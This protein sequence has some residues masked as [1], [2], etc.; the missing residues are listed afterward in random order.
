MRTKNMYYTEGANTYNCTKDVSISV[1]EII[2]AENLYCSRSWDKEYATRYVLDLKTAIVEA[3]Y[4]KHYRGQRF[5]KSVLELPISYGCIIGCRHCASSQ[6]HHKR[7]LC[8]EELLSIFQFVASKHIPK[9]NY[10][11]RVSFAGIGE[12]AL[13]PHLIEHALPRMLS[14]YPNC[15]FTLTT[16]G[17]DPEYLPFT[18]MLAKRFPIQYLQ[19]SYL[20][21]D[22][23]LISKIIPTA[24]IFQ[25]NYNRLFNNIIHATSLPI[26][27]N[28]VV[29][30]DF[31][32][33]TATALRLAEHISSI[34]DRV[35]VRVSCMNETEPSRTYGLQPPS[36]ETLKSIYKIFT[37]KGITTYVFAAHHDDKLN[38]GQLAGKYQ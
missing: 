4:F 26:R 31:N 23:S 22:I 17:C 18:E 20:Q 33:D 34:K 25:F 6:L 7:F 13:V 15:Y 14:L 21:D 24:S 29:I 28:Y 12:G 16:S 38:C 36:M 8:L 11:F 19:I 37:N 35:I 2:T 3:S 5:V 10:K 1:K 32:D 30:K 9:K 27:I